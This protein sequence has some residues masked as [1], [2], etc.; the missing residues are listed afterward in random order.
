MVAH[1]GSGD[2]WPEHTLTAYLNATISGAD[3][4]EIS[5][6]STSDGVLVCHHDADTRRVTGVEGEVAAL[7]F[8]QLRERPVDARRWLGGATAPEPISPV[9][10]V[11]AALP[12][13]AL[14]FIEDKDGTNTM[15]LLEILDSQPR[16]TERFVWK[17]WAF[18]KQVE[19]A[20]S[21]GYRSWGYLTSD[22]LGRVE[23]AFTMHDAL[24]VPVGAADED[25]S[26]LVDT[27]KPVMAWEV[28]T[29]SE[30]RRLRSLGVTG[31]MCSN[32]PY[33]LEKAK[34]ATS[35]SFSSGRRPAGDLPANYLEGWASQPP[36]QPREP[37][38]ILSGGAS[39]RYLLGSLCPVA[40]GDFELTFTVGWEAAPDGAHSRAGV[41][42]GLVDDSP[43]HPRQPNAAGAYQAFLNSD[44]R[45]ALAYQAAAWSAS[46]NL[47]TLDRVSTGEVEITVT[48][49]KQKI[50]ISADGNYSSVN[51]MDARGGYL[52]L[53]GEQVSQGARFS[54]IHV[55]QL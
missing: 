44:G 18:A 15:Q 14:V 53:W 2:N 6:R 27:G 7:T 5:V 10:D 21:R 13:D 20:R 29:R 34:P 32:V 3:A 31:L 22:T 45:V 51:H 43:Y 50:S 35:D 33:V 16:S 42:F 48:V 37:S 52:W 38:L 17:Q 41:A 39:P 46:E 36:L 4:I 1:R 23:E 9:V 30:R 11:L 54:G 55:T 49:E 25:I 47:T 26:R 24:G 28:H 40:A 8:A 19:S 12:E